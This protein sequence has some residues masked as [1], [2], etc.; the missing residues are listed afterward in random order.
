MSSTSQGNLDLASLRAAVGAPVVGPDDDGWDAARQAWNL[1][2]DLHPAAV[3]FADNADDVVA[4]VNFARERG[5]RVA[6]NGTGHGA[7]AL[8][9]LDGVVL[10]KTERMR[11]VTVD[12][13]ARR[14]R[15]EAG[16]L[17]GDLGPAAG[18]H[19]LTEIGRAHV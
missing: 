5:L 19:G 7:G 14:A 1:T 8:G 10:L 4:V 17:G 2:A 11:G 12:P 3:A 15:V 18:E 9:S 16:A 13:G 6:A